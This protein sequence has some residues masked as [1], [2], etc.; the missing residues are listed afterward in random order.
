MV[1]SLASLASGLKVSR[2]ISNIVARGFFVSN[3]RSSWSRLD[4]CW[5]GGFSVDFVHGI[6]LI[7][8]DLLV[9]LLDSGQIELLWGLVGD[10]K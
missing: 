6:T 5:S 4:H 7:L 2:T 3:F 8:L 9:G 10:C 1:L